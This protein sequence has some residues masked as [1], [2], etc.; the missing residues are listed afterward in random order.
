MA[1]T[2][3]ALPVLLTEAEAARYLRVSV[4]TVMRERRAGRLRAVRIRGR[5]RY[6]VDDLG[7]YV[8]RQAGEGC[9]DDRA[10]GRPQGGPGWDDSPKG[11]S[12]SASSGSAGA[13]TPGSG[14]GPGSTPS[15]DR[16]AALASALRILRKPGSG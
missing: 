6:R 4:W 15:P 10:P 1:E 13:A 7:A 2:V 14:A 11:G 8:E 12:S 5:W 9:R 16:P 3:S